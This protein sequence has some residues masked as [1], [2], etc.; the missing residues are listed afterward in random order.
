LGVAV[1]LVTTL[2]LLYFL[3]IFLLADSAPA[4]VAVSLFGIGVLAVHSAMSVYLGDGWKIRFR[5]LDRE[6]RF[7]RFLGRFD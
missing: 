3:R 6:N 2:I 7:I 1:W 5:K 4:R